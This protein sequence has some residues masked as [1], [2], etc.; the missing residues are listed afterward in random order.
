ML[1]AS[2]AHEKGCTEYAQFQA[3][4]TKPVDA[5][6]DAVEGAATVAAAAEEGQWSHMAKPTGEKPTTPD[7]GGSHAVYSPG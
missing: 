7:G 1:Q 5:A 2:I 6:V 3:L 4:E